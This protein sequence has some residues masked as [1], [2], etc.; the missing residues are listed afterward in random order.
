[1]KK[2]YDNIYILT[3]NNRIDIR[4]RSL[5][6]TINK[7]SI[8]YFDSVLMETDII[9]F[10][11]PTILTGDSITYFVDTVTARI[12]FSDY[13]QVVYKKIKEEKS[14]IKIHHLQRSPMPPTSSVTLVNNN[15]IEIF[16]NGSIFEGL[17]LLNLGYWA[18]SEKIATL[19]PFDYW[20]DNK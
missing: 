7:D 15:A 18:W 2:F 6:H 1:M 9:D 11:S 17:D 19:L 20:P 5:Q 16:S 14:Y 10:V 8:A 3:G 4:S 13:L 12:R